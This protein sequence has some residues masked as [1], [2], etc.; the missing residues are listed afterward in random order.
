MT[1]GD[2]MIIVLRHGYSVGGDEFLDV[3]SSMDSISSVDSIASIMNV[4]DRTVKRRLKKYR[5]E[6]LLV[7]RQYSNNNYIW[8]IGDDAKENWNGY[9]ALHI[10]K[11]R[12][13]IN[14]FKAEKH[15]FDSLTRDEQ[16]NILIDIP[17]FDSD[18]KELAEDNNTVYYR[19]VKKILTTKNVEITDELKMYVDNLW[20][21][22]RNDT[23]TN[24]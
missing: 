20:E 22:Y 24:K 7:S 14:V 13:Y 5:D 17:I 4:T 19:K 18:E 8:M 12:K 3:L 2:I 11:Y 10:A 9:E 16:E 1:K 6:G 21:E 23:R 15:E